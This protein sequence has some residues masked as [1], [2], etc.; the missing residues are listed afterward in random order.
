MAHLQALLW[1]PQSVPENKRLWFEYRDLGARREAIEAEAEAEAKDGPTTSL[2]LDCS[3]SSHT[4]DE[5][6]NIQGILSAG[7][8]QLGSGF[9]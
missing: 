8:C 4:D 2:E 6:I 1:I 9:G 5:A 3:S 7:S